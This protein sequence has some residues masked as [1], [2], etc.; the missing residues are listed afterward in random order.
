LYNVVARTP[1]DLQNS[2]DLLYTYFFKWG[3][4]VNTMKTKI[5]VFRKRGHIL[6]TKNGLIRVRQ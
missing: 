2:L 4:E 3:L 1:E 6:S 5:V